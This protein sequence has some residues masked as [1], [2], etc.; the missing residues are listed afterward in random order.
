MNPNART[1]RTMPQPTNSRA[2][3]PMQ[4]PFTSTTT[5]AT[6]TMNTPSTS[7]RTVAL[8]AAIFS[9]FGLG[10]SHAQLIT[11]YETGFESTGEAWGNYTVGTLSGQPSDGA[12]QWISGGDYTGNVVL[13]SAGPSL[14]TG[15]DQRIAVNRPTSNDPRYFGLQF[16]GTN[17]G[18]GAIMVSEVPWVSFSFDLAISGESN[19][20]VQFILGSTA[21][22]TSGYTL[23]L[24]RP[25]GPTSDLGFYIRN[26]GGSWTQIGSFTASLDTF[27]HLEALIDTQ[28]ELFTASVYN[29]DKSS[30]LGSASGNMSYVGTNSN[31]TWLN[32]VIGNIDQIGAS[33][34][35]LDNIL[36]Q[37]AIPEPTALLM[38]LGGGTWFFVRRRQRHS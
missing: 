7:L 33:T 32:R 29:A 10:H 2:R 19:A 18:Q 26:N 14:P 6:S 38:L 24:R 37:S 11:Y 25:A 30:L 17:A 4:I 20:A 22:G 34:F 1:V 9:L 12:R 28:N 8:A 23:S 16:A 13:S 5:P 35:Y 21:N 15:E 36:V 3:A 31:L 27:Y